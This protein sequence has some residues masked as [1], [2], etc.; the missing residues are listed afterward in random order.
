MNE[1][2]RIEHPSVPAQIKEHGT[3]DSDCWEDIMTVRWGQC[4]KQ[5][6]NL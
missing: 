1:Q 3:K 6:E 5:R 4:D 2:R